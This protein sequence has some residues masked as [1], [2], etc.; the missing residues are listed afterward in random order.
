[1]DKNLFEPILDNNEEILK[2]YLPDKKRAWFGT[3]A[4][5]IIMALWLVP[6]TIFAFFGDVGAG[7][8]LSLFD[9]LFLICPVI[10]IALWCKKTVYAVTNK[11][12]I[13]RTGYIGVDFKSL[14]YDMLGAITVNVN[15]WDKIL[16]RD[17]GSIAFGSMSSP[18]TS[19]GGAKF[20]F[21]FV[22]KP[23]ETNK[24]VKAIIDKYRTDKNSNNNKI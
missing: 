3:I 10:M 22:T 11:R 21:M 13:I 12:I 5:A 7:I 14:E 17:T 23:Y 19:Q 8:A 1:M 20:A 24:E 4:Y 15:V 2:M 16:K 18:L 9:L 6:S